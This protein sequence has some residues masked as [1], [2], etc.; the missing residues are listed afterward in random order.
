MNG[1]CSRLRWIAA[2]ALGILSVPARGQEAAPSPPT[3][4]DD[5]P[6]AV[7]AYLLHLEQQVRQLQQ[8]V[9]ELEGNRAPAPAA[10]SAPRPTPPPPQIYGYFQSQFEDV[11]PGASRFFVRRARIGVRGTLPEAFAYA[12]QTE[13]AGTSVTLRDLYLERAIAGWGALRFGQFKVP[14]AYEGLES[15]ARIPTIERALITELVYHERDIGVMLRTP[16]RPRGYEFSAGIFNGRGRNQFDAQGHHIGVGRLVLRRPLLGGEGT[17]GLSAQ[18]GESDNLTQRRRE[19]EAFAVDAQFVRGPL[20][21]RAE[22]LTGKRAEARPRGWYVLGTYRLS[23]RTEA[24]L[25]YDTLDG[26][27]T[28]GDAHRI[29]VGANYAFSPLTRLMLNYEAVS[30]RTRGFTTAALGSGLRLRLQTLLP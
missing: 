4:P 22:F 28:F 17:L 25:R 15:S 5:L 13:V 6:P 9:H 14:F 11:E 21:L 18:V 30:G 10:P 8:R 27:G 26:D 1:T 20:T 3:L 7:R 24:V 16:D 23:P 19:G 12:G 29:T 2:L